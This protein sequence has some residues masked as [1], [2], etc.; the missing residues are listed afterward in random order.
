M[1]YIPHSRLKLEP[2]DITVDPALHEVA[3]IHKRIGDRVYEAWTPSSHTG[4]QHQYLSCFPATR[5]RC[6]NG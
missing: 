1:S 3:H 5:Y 2:Q 4:A 6:K